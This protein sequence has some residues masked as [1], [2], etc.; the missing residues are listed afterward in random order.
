MGAPISV[1]GDPRPLPR[2]TSLEQVACLDPLNCQASQMAR[3]WQGLFSLKLDTRALESR[4]EPR[5]GVYWELPRQRKVAL[6]SI[7]GPYGV[8]RRNMISVTE[9]ECK[10]HRQ[11]NK[12]PETPTH[13][14]NTICMKTT[15]INYKLHHKN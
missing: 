6:I 12:A 4:G 9:H 15:C 7:S 13:K 2:P 10:S 5:S 8:N 1:P 3:T 11:S 14:S